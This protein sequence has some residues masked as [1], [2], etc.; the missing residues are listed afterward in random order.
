MEAKRD[1]QNIRIYNIFYLISLVLCIEK[2]VAI[3]IV[4]TS[5]IAAKG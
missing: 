4:Q 5:G 2:G 1:I 3:P